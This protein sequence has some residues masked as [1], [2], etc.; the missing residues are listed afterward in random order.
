MNRIAIIGKMGSGKTTMANKLIDYGYTKI[1]FGDKVKELCVDLFSMSYKN[2]EL[3]QNVAEQMKII[4]KDVW[5]SYV[6]NKINKEHKDKKWVLDDCR[7]PNEYDVLKQ[8]GFVFIYI[9]I[10]YESQIENLKTI[11]GDKYLDHIQR[12]NHISESFVEKLGNMP[13]VIITNRNKSTESLES[14]ID[15]II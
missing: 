13:N 14:F 11:Y 10:D 6:I 4:D 9:N 2:R 7:F 3:I 5:V 1:S 12:M 15:N 8:I